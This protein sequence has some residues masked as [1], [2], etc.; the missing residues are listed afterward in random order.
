MRNT[1]GGTGGASSRP[2]TRPLPA[3]LF[4]RVRQ[5]YL[6]T[7]FVSQLCHWPLE[8]RKSR[9]TNV[10]GPAE[11]DYPRAGSYSLAAG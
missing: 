6:S 2:L 7:R 11:A 5:V 4:R 1:G 3:F 8:P 9:K 10:Q